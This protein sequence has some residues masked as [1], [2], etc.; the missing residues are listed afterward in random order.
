MGGY[1]EGVVGEWVGMV[2]GLW[3]GTVKGL[4]V[5]WLGSH[6]AYKGNVKH[7]WPVSR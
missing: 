4:W 1:G 2:K 3:V 5:S 7:L 6:R